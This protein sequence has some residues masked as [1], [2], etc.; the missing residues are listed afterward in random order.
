MNL[1]V[2]CIKIVYF[3]IP[4]TASTHY[5]DYGINCLFMVYGTAA[6]NLWSLR[7]TLQN[8]LIARYK[9]L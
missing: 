3:L 8:A 7:Y 1:I 4:P 2:Q 5:F 6:H 9:A